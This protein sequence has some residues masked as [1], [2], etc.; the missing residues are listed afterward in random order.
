M[1]S[2]RILKMTTFV[3]AYMGMEP[4]SYSENMH[5]AHYSYITLPFCS[6]GTLVDLL[7]KAINKQQELSLGLQKYLFKQIVKCLDEMHNLN[8][9][10]HLDIKPD[11]IVFTNDLGLAL[12]DFGHVNY[13]KHPLAATTGTDQYMAPE[14]RRTLYKQNM[15]YLPEK[16]DVFSL[17]V[18]LFILIFGKMPFH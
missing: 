17:G 14:V 7:I 13:L 12:I 9:L 18:C 4:F 5:M 16:A 3:G 15:A 10:A 11:N 1:D 8:G 2:P 6:K